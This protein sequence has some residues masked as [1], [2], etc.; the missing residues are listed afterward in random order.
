MV[1]VG[2]WAFYMSSISAFLQSKPQMLIFLINQAAINKNKCVKG[3]SIAED[4]T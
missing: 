4:I 3:V 1:D 2:L